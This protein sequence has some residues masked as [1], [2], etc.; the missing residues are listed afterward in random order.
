[1]ASPSS[2]SSPSGDV[3]AR[4]GF[5][6]HISDPL[7]HVI[8]ME[9]TSDVLAEDSLATIDA[10]LRDP[11]QECLD[12]VVRS[13]DPRGRKDADPSDPE[14][15]R[16]GPVIEERLKQLVLMGKIDKTSAK[17]YLQVRLRK[18][19]IATGSRR[20]RRRKKRLALRRLKLTRRRLKRLIRKLKR[21]MRR[22]PTAVRKKLRLRIAE[23]RQ[24]ILGKRQMR[25]QAQKA[26]DPI[27]QIII[28]AEEKTAKKQWERRLGTRVDV[29][30]WRASKTFK[31]WLERMEANFH[32]EDE[33]RSWFAERG[34]LANKGSN[35]ENAAIKRQVQSESDKCCGEPETG[36][37]SSTVVISTSGTGGSGGAVASASQNA[38]PAA[39]ATPAPDSSEKEDNEKGGGNEKLDPEDQE[40]EQTLNDKTPAKNDRTPIDCS[41][42]GN[43]DVFSH[44]DLEQAQSNGHSLKDIHQWLKDNNFKDWNPESKDQK[45]MKDPK[46]TKMFPDTFYSGNDTGT[47]NAASNCFSEGFLD[48]IRQLLT[49]SQQKHPDLAVFTNRMREE[50]ILQAQL[51]SQ[52]PIPFLQGSLPSNLQVAI[53]IL[54]GNL[55]N[56]T[57]ATGTTLHQSTYPAYHAF[58]QTHGVWGEDQY[59]K[60]MDATVPVQLNTGG[61]FT[62]HATCDDVGEFYIDDTLVLTSDNWKNIESTT[63]KLT[64]GVHSIRVKGIN[65]GGPASLG[66]TLTDP[67]GNLAFCTKNWKNYAPSAE[68]D[69]FP[70]DPIISL[71][72]GIWKIVTEQWDDSIAKHL[73][74]EGAY[75]GEGTHHFA[76]LN[77][78]NIYSPRE[79]QVRASDTED[80][81]LNLLSA[82]SDTS[83]YVAGSKFTLKFETTSADQLAEQF[84]PIPKR[85]SGL[86]PNPNG[87]KGE[88]K[89]DSVVTYDVYQQSMRPIIDS[90]FNKVHQVLND[91]TMFFVVSDLYTGAIP[92]QENKPILDEETYKKKLQTEVTEATQGQIESLRVTGIPK[93]SAKLKLE[94]DAEKSVD[95]LPSESIYPVKHIHYGQDFWV[96]LANDGTRLSTLHTVKSGETLGGITQQHGA[97]L[98]DTILLNP[99][100]DIKKLPK[101]KRGDRPQGDNQVGKTNRNPNW[102]F[103]GE[104]ILVPKGTSSENAQSKPVHAHI[105]SLVDATFVEGKVPSSLGS[106]NAHK[107]KL[108]QGHIQILQEEGSIAKEASDIAVKNSIPVNQINAQPFA[109]RINEAIENRLKVV[110]TKAFSS[111][112]TISFSEMDTKT[113]PPHSTETPSS[114][115]SRSQKTPSTGST[116][117]HQ[118]SC[119]FTTRATR[120]C[121]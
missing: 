49:Y 13:S 54:F 27:N 77:D 44:S 36:D 65:K 53:D 75:A 89:V 17:K 51:Q 57:D 11:L 12:C 50:S 40:L 88:G 74:V 26:L 15:M 113:S 67:D 104:G 83:A 96:G 28:S 63:L 19:V 101:W 62:V 58:L 35:Q 111:K 39:V 8:H 3:Q 42:G 102:I 22:R 100:F 14:M 68:P 52:K 116:Q 60:G 92:V 115:Q 97:N 34:N 29:H 118:T 21:R 38:A 66:M 41:S 4:A 81:P 46:M 76:G 82:L 43:P 114:C 98:R 7:A 37:M 112:Q 107:D 99:Q 56:P 85:K 71:P 78:L 64:K 86:P 48:R 94:S 90:W 69:V 95:P 87:Y 16:E 72:E 47:P 120:E 119:G 73:H 18:K 24:G 23:L 5:S 70:G 61:E 108:K 30:T 20:K 117:H 10:L 106:P 9:T 93:F 103:P 31:G 105:Q 91:N 59:S 110:G 32:P 33:S 2:P 55:G 84:A 79:F 45:K 6:T 1:M 121:C 25:R 80:N 109:D